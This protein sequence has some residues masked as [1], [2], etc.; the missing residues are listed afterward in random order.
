[1]IKSKIESCLK[2]AVKEKIP[3][4]VFVPENEKFG[5]YSTN[6]ALKLAKVLNKN[7][8]E[9]AEDIIEKLKAQNSKL[10]EKIEVAP[11]GFINFFITQEYLA[12]NL[13]EILNKKDKF[14]QGE[15]K[16]QTIS[17]NILLL[18]SPNP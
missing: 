7:P 15:N 11:P 14:G 3:V 9:I 1:M 13:K 18:I 10:F 4:E 6:A 17:L 5:H 2:K 8:M 16:K 12:E